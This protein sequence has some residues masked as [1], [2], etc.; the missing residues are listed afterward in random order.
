VT[1]L[2]DWSDAT[3]ASSYRLQVSA[4]SNFSVLWIDTYTS[5]SDYQAPPGVLAYNS[6]YYWRVKSLNSSDSSGFSN[7]QD[8]FTKLFP[9][10]ADEITSA[11]EKKKTLELQGMNMDKSKRFTVEICKDTLFNNLLLSID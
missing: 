11:K 5:S 8:F 7:A 9:G 6:R 2:F 1:P 4:F 3:G 10:T